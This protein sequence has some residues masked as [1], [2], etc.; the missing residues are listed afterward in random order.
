[1]Q[2]D[3]IINIAKNTIIKMKKQIIKICK[4]LNSKINLLSIKSI[5]KNEIF[6][7]I[8]FFKFITILDKYIYDKRIS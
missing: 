3:K 8:N 4:S 6:V 5:L 2:I 7:I 1:M